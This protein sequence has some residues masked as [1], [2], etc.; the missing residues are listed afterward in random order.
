MKDNRDICVLIQSFSLK[1]E[2]SEITLAEHHKTNL[3][4]VSVDKHIAVFGTMEYYITIKRI[5][6]VI[7]HNRVPPLKH[8]IE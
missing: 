1:L 2:V 8:Y 3:Y 5:N 7:C 4:D 6:N